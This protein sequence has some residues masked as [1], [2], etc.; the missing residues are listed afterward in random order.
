MHNGEKQGDQRSGLSDWAAGK[1]SKTREGTLLGEAAKFVEEGGVGD[2][3]AVGVE[4]AGFAGGGER[5]N[6]KGHGDAVVSARFDLGAVQFSGGA[7]FDAQTIRPLFDLGAHTLEIFGEGGD[8][9]AFLDAEF[10]GVANLNSL[11]GIRPESSEHGQLVDEKRDEVARDE[12]AFE[13]SSLHGKIADQFTLLA[14]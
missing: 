9:V 12:A 7:P 10:C 2:G 5:S 4:D 13:P 8:A 1:G 11:L 3:G 6:S 14:L